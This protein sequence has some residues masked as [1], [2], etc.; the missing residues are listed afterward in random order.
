MPY[1]NMA[2]EPY[3]TLYRRAEVDCWGVSVEGGGHA[4]AWVGITGQ[5][6]VES[7]EYGQKVSTGGATPWVGM[8]PSSGCDVLTRVVVYSGIKVEALFW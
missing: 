1:T 8:F 2:Y 6:G 3:P 5:G 4:R 7:E